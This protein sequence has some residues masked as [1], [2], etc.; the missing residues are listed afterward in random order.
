MAVDRDAMIKS[1]FFGYAQKNWSQATAGNKVW[2][3]PDVLRFDH[4]VN[5]AK[6]LLASLGWKDGDG[7]GVLEDARGN[8]VIFTMKTNGDNRI[9]VAMANFV[10]DDLAKVGIRVILTPV[11]FNTL[12]TNIRDD[13]QYDAVLLGLQSGVPPDPGMGQNVW[14]SSGRTHQWNVA[15]PK[16]ETPEEARIDALV[17]VIVSEPDLE[18]R[19]AAWREVETVV[20]EQ[21]WIIWLP[22]QTMKVPVRNRFGNLVPSVIPHTLIRGIDQVFVKAGAEPS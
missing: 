13:F 14:R 12:I 10:R 4:D 17:D 2:H 8:A 11:D 6:R 19:R 1:I 21:C 16:P 18:K 7:D 20:N 22:T 15:Q 5:E 3:N 9:R